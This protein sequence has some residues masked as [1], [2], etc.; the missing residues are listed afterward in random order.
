MDGNDSLVAL[1]AN[2]ILSGG[3]G[4][5]QLYS[6]AAGTVMTGGAGNDLFYFGAGNG[7]AS[8]TDYTDG[9]DAIAFQSSQ[10]ANFAAVQSAAA[11][12]GANVVITSG[13]DVYTLQNVTLASLSSGDFVFV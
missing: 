10:F 5:D 2:N 1:A 7:A 11:Q 3:N 12:V 8:I 6:Q 13:S 4:N 9:Q